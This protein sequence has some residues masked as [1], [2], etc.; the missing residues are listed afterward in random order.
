MQNS[1]VDSDYRSA[2]RFLLKRINYE[3]K[4]VA[5]QTM[6]HFKLDRMRKLLDELGNPQQRVPVVHVAGTKGKGSTATMIAAVLSSAGFRT[7]LYTSP[8]LNCLEERW[9]ID[10]QNCTQ[11]DLVELVNQLRPAVRKLEQQTAVIPTYFE[12]TTALAWLHFA[13]ARTDIAVIEVGM[14]GRLDSTNICHPLISVITS[15]SLDHTQQL[16]NTLAAIAT[17]KAGIVKP[18]ITV[19]SGVTQ[20][21]PQKAIQRV[22]KQQQA[23]LFS[24]NEHFSFQVV[25]RAF[26]SNR[27]SKYPPHRSTQSTTARTVFDYFE[28]AA[29]EGTSLTGLTLSL[30]GDHQAAN[31]A[32]AVCAVRQLQRQGWTIHDRHIRQGLSNVRCP[33]RVEILA[34]HPLVIVDAAHNLASAE[35][36]EAALGHYIPSRASAILIFATSQDKDA[37]GMLEV[38]LPRFEHCILTRYRNNPRALPAE[39]L[40][41]IIE[42]MKRTAGDDRFPTIHMSATPSEAWQTAREIAQSSDLICVTGSFFV[43][44]EIRELLDHPQSTSQEW[45]RHNQQLPAGDVAH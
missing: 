20:S 40:L 8:H 19:I 42:P 27:S 41:A 45:L 21:E 11:R 34:E 38:L 9:R 29:A 26:S 17:E 18:G 28:A 30:A 10:G 25:D 4:P 1:A 12:L 33:A 22:V 36:L 2:L 32:I 3:R 13:K 43:A 35:A 14:G 31:A 39:Q 5:A 37:A 15:I 7:G 16:G 6:R 44:A 23:P 24:L